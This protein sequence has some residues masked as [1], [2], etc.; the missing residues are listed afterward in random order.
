MDGDVDGADAQIDDALGLPGGEVCEG[1]IVAHEE[2]EAGVVVFEVEGVAAA[3]GHLVDEAEEAVVGAGAGG[4]HEVGV[5]VKAEVFSLGLFYFEGTAEAVGGF[6]D[7]DGVGV[8]A[9]EAVVEDIDDVVASDGEEFFAG[10]DSGAL[11]GGTGVDGCDDG[12]H[13]ASSAFF[14]SCRLSIL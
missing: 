3:G 10:A 7:Q 8:V 9:E 4:V 13:S 1:D 11:G 12:A 14:S 6:E 5:E 2:A